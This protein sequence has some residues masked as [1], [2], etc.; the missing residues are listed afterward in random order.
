[1]LMQYQTETRP[2]PASA[3]RW[4]DG[5]AS[6]A[7]RGE[8][9][10]G[11]RLLFDLQSVVELVEEAAQRDAQCQFDDLRFGE[12]R[13]QPREQRAWDVLTRAMAVP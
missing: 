13:A 6:P 12:M 4:C 9:G 8:P 11:F 7:E 10:G 1:M 3:C 2:S 5:S